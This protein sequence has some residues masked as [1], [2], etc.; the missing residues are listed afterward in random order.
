MPVTQ[1]PFSGEHDLCA[2]AA[3]ARAFPADH[4]R[5][6]DLP[7]RLSSWALDDPANVALWVDGTD[8]LMA[9][10]VLQAPFWTIDYTIHPGA[11]AGLHA[12]VLAWADARARA[13]L[14]TPDSRPAWFVTVFADQTARTRDLEAAGFACQADVGEDSWS[15]VFMGRPGQ[16][17][18]PDA[19][20]SDGFAIRPL[21]G[22]VE[23]EAYVELQ[24]EVFDSRN[25]TVAWRARTLH[26][27]EYVPALDLVA[28]APGGRLAGFCI[29]WLDP[30]AP[31]GQVEPLGVRAEFRQF[32]LGRAL[33]LECLR[34]LQARGVEDVY[35]ETDNYRD[36]ALE[37][38]ESAGFHVL[39]DVWMFRKDYA[40]RLQPLRDV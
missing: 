32:G 35:V 1:R 23:V 14:D 38:Y 19:P 21:A 36:A 26:R 30:S 37:L 4:L 17:P 39:R 34:R 29:G 9:W 16:A 25:M 11:P 22:E 27:P 13:V 5:V 7:W 12:Q 18:V 8:Q 40:Q 20:L 15:K 2:M 10:A 28:V 6:T 31:R 3:L 24:R 33:L